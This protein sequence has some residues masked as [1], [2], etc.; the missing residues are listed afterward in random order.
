MKNTSFTTYQGELYGKVRKKHTLRALPLILGRRELV[1]LKLPPTKVRDGVDDDPRDATPKVD[2]LWN[3]RRSGRI[4]GEHGTHTNLMEEETGKT[5]S[6]DGVTDQ[7]VPADPLS[8]EPIER[9]KVCASVELLCG[10]FVENGGG[11]RSRVE[12]HDRGGEGDNAEC[13]G[14]NSPSCILSPYLETSDHF[15]LPTTATSLHV[16]TTI[17]QLFI[18][19]TVSAMSKM[20]RVLNYPG[21]PPR[22]PQSVSFFSIHIRHGPATCSPPLVRSHSES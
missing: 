17:T 7:E 11:G 1:W 22:R 12:G 10:I 18:I 3:L 21:M 14:D 13:L 4:S 9:G 19:I 15:V 2:N 6:D 20:V 5:G 8:L 16:Q